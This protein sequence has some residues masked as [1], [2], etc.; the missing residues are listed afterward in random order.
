MGNREK[1]DYFILSRFNLWL[2]NKD[3]RGNKVRST[4]WLEHRFLLF[5]QYCLQSIINQT[6]KE[7]DWIVLFDSKTPEIFKEKIR[8][9]Q[10]KCPQ[11]KP[12]FVEPEKGRYFA[13]I[14]RKEVSIRLTKGAGRLLTTYLDND[15]ALDIHFVEDIQRRALDLPSG[16]FIYYTDGY[17]YFTDYKYLMRIHYPRNHFVSVVEKGIQIQ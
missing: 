9:L 8:E 12:V 3:K 7:F 11:L 10:T 17:Q 13:E 5:E 4:Q 6:C 14:F 15:D 2:W 16:T 1:L